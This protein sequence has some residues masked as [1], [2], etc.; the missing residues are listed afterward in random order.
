MHHVTK[1]LFC[2]ETLRVSDIFCA[3]H[4]E[5]SVVHVAISMFHAGYV[6]AP[7]ETQVVPTWLTKAA[8]TYPAW[9]IL[10]ATCTTDNSW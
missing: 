3:H 8:A 1:I 4:Q 5:L 2:H 6:A 7:S 10:I 9:N